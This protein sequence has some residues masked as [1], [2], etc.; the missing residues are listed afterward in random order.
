MTAAPAFFDWYQT[1]RD[2][3]PYPWQIRLAQALADGHWPDSLSLPTASGKTTLLDTWAWARIRSFPGVPTRLYWC[4]DRQVVVD[5]VARQAETLRTAVPGLQL[6]ALHGGLDLDDPGVTDPLAPAV[7]TTTVDQL[8]SR[9]LFRAYGSSRHV[10][11]IHAALAGNDALLVLDEAHIAAPFAALLESIAR[12]R[13]DGLGLP[14]RTLLLSATPRGGLGFALDETDY[15]C[16]ALRQKLAAP[17]LATLRECS[18]EALVQTLCERALALRAAEAGVVAVV[19]NRVRTARQVAEALAAHGET[20]LIT[21]RIRRPDRERLLAEFLPRLEAGARAK[22]R[23]TLF[24]VATQTIEVGADFDFD[25]LVTESAPLSALLQR[26]GRVNRAG[27]LP[28]A[29]IEIVHAKSAREIDPVY[30]DDMKTAWNW[31]TARAGKSRQLDL[32][33]LALRDAEL[34]AEAEP[35]YPMLGSADLRLLAQTSTAATI[36]IAPWLRGYASSAEAAI[37]WRADMPADPTHWDAYLRALPPASRETLT[38]PVWE[39]REWLN[40][41]HPNRPVARWDGDN[42]RVSPGAETRLHAGAT[43]IV[44]AN[45]GGCDAWGWAPDSGE[46]VSDLGD[47]PFRTRIHPALQA[48]A[49]DWLAAYTHE[50]EPIDDDELL[51]L[52]GIRP[53]QSWRLQDYPGG[54]A[55]IYGAPEPERLTGVEVGLDEHSR[56]VAEYARRFI[57]PVLSD[58]L[59]E[60][61]CRAALWHDIGKADDR[62]QLALG[63]TGM[64]KLA[65]SRARSREQARLARSLS[66]LPA[67]WRHEIASAA[68]LAA[69]DELI[70]YL[71]ATHHGR[72]RCWLSARPDPQHWAAAGG[73]SWAD[74]YAR[75]NEQFG[76]WGLTYLETLVRLADWARSRAEAEGA[77]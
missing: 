67:G 57:P 44:P 51:A 62:F 54:V 55:V 45:Y 18:R 43:L 74:R 32:S 42:G 2:R 28:T 61:V 34:P 39:L 76:L 20:C 50:W 35:D 31:L 59:A 48:E 41:R 19:C 22:G 40:S 9:L 49:A 64:E 75:L 69:T 70:G 3:A 4:V 11:P 30:G 21:G 26:A 33:P 52:A 73:A 7:I 1:L 17:K 16:A 23:A 65:K 24:A 8:G 46:P 58:D 53:E 37:V 72:G 27:E 13:A 25:A 68:G 29:S 6:A 15:A 66:G 10:A 14:W 77:A 38:L 60:A 5:Q 63:A 56:G 36:D 47:T 71:V 12:L